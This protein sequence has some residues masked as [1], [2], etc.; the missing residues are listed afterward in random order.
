M[1]QEKSGNWEIDEIRVIRKFPTL[2]FL[3]IVTLISW[4][5]MPSLLCF[6][7]HYFVWSHITNLGT[8][9]GCSFSYQWYMAFIFCFCFFV[10]MTKV[11][12]FS[13][14][15]VI[16]FLC[17]IAFSI[18]QITNPFYL[19]RHQWVFRRMVFHPAPKFS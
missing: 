4:Y 5:Y 17:N 14:S 12:A 3:Q 19:W 13:V 9:P 2:Q 11:T 15:F 10:R 6:L 18:Y 1:L 7:W 8:A 16:Y